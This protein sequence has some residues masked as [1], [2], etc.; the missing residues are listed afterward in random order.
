MITRRGFLKAIAAGTAIYPFRNAIASIKGDKVFNAYNI[1]TK[2]SLNAV[3]F[4]SGRYDYSAL[5]EINYFLRC[6]Y[7]NEVETIDVRLIELISSI[8]NIFGSD[9]QLQIISGYRSLKYNEYLRSIGRK[10]SKNS[11]HLLGLALDFTIP[12]IDNFELFRAAKSFRIGGVGLY[13]E[14]VHVDTGQIRYW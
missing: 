3:Y 10:V 4:A 8:H 11:L 6:H 12:E 1:H 7:T 2:E 9:K 5:R 13:P 14:F